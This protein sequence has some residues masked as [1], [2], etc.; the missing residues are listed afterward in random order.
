MHW[1]VGRR[2]YLFLDGGDFQ[3]RIIGY[4]LRAIGDDFELE[5]INAATLKGVH[6]MHKSIVSCPFL[7]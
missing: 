5:F 4:R 1:L 3:L 6:S 7:A 2:D